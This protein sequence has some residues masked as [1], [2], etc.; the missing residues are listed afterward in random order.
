ML[1]TYYEFTLPVKVI[2][3]HTALNNLPAELVAA[4]VSRPLI[5]TDPGVSKAGLIQHVLSAFAE[6]GITIAGVYDQVP[7]ESSTLLV[8]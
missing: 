5:I 3:G 2:S 7:A 8:N 4:K 6:T 1:P